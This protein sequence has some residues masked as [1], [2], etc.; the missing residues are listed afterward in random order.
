MNILL[1]PDRALDAT[2]PSNLLNTLTKLIL[3]LKSR[4]IG[5]LYLW[6]NSV[7]DLEKDETPVRLSAYAKIADYNEDSLRVTVKGNADLF[8]ENQLKELKREFINLGNKTINNRDFDL[9][10][11]INYTTEDDYHRA[12]GKVITNHKTGGFTAAAFDKLVK[13]NMDEP[14]EIDLIIKT[15][16][17]KGN[18]NLGGFNPVKSPDAE[19]IFIED[20][21]LD[22]GPDKILEY[23]SVAQEAIQNP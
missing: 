4:G 6:C 8:E 16:A 18:R 21:F 12:I 7:K 3:G 5:S 13:E 14:D 20:F 15:G 19:I 2:N 22:L 10:Y 9:Y 23:I 11:F 1:I 17:T